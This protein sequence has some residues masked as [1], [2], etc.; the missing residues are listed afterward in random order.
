MFIFCAIW[1]IDVEQDRGKKKRGKEFRV[2]EEDE[3]KFRI[4]P[5]RSLSALH[6]TMKD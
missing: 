1:V 2:L 3:D 5:R 4:P 6:S